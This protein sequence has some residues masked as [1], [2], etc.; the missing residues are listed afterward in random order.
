MTQN[1]ERLNMSASALCEFERLL[2]NETSPWFEYNLEM[3]SESLNAFSSKNWHDLQS[4]ALSFSACVQERCAEAVGDS[5]SNDAIGVLTTLLASSPY[6][7]VAAIAASQLD[8]MEIKLPVA[9]LG[10]LQQLLDQL[11]DRHST[12]AEDVQRL[13]LHLC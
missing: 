12:R 10:R 6:L 1:D 9:L 8:D 11:K 2:G 3:A 5:G 4:K 7:D 13:I